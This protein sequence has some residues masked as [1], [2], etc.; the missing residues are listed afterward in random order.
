MVKDAPIVHL[1]CIFNITFPSVV[2]ITACFQIISINCIRVNFVHGVRFRAEGSP[3]NA[4]LPPL[5][6]IAEIFGA[7][8]KTRGFLQPVC[9][10]VALLMIV[11]LLCFRLTEASQETGTVIPA[12]SKSFLLHSM[13]HV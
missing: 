2:Q 1:H 11:E 13:K 6:F 3:L 9:A 10:A 12:E 8:M 4:P 7:S 5:H